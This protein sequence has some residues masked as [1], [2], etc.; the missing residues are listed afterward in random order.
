MNIKD[1]WMI[2]TT[3]STG[4]RENRK[5]P[6][7]ASADPLVGITVNPFS[8][9]N[10]TWICKMNKAKKK[11]SERRNFLA[12]CSGLLG[13]LLLPG[14]GRTVE[15]KAK[16]KQMMC[17]VELEALSTARPV[18][19]PAM[20]WEISEGNRLRIYW[21][22]PKNQGAAE[23]Y[24]EMNEVGEAIWRACDGRKTPAE[25]AGMLQRRY[26]VFRSRAYADCLSFLAE[27]KTRGLIEA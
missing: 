26:S 1:L 2:P 9:E 8:K 3:A 23:P 5:T 25:I 16:F 18:R 27:L 14:L 19:S 11:K 13:S 7:V 24:Y 21:K 12:A 4:T 22:K 6:S 20:L 17:Q 15:P 10:P